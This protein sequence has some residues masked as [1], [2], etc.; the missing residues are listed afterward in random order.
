M[1]V[2]LAQRHIRICKELSLYISYHK[3]SKALA[4]ARAS[5]QWEAV[6]CPA[7]E[8]EA[9]DLRVPELCVSV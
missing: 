1:H 6:A 8:C 9:V 4:A 3:S 5:N 2:H 7:V